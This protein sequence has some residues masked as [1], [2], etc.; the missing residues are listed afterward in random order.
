MTRFSFCDIGFTVNVYAHVAVNVDT[1]V[2]FMFNVNLIFTL[3]RDFDV[4]TLFPFQFRDF[5]VDV[6]VSFSA[7]PHLI[8]MF[9][10]LCY[11]DV[12]SFSVS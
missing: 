4:E 7:A 9:M 3:F 2:S 10:L 1:D 6:I 8:S 11:Y 12:V 5:D